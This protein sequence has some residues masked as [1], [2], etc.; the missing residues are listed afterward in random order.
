MDQKL[1]SHSLQHYYVAVGTASAKL[2][3]NRVPG[4]FLEA[5][6][7]LIAFTMH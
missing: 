6:S 2:V 3:S 1:S 5:L 7:S 4:P